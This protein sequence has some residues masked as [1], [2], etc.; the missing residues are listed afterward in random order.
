[1]VGREIHQNQC[2]S[3]NPFCVEKD[4]DASCVRSEETSCDSSFENYCE[5]SLL[6]TCTL[7]HEQATD[8][9]LRGP[10]CVADPDITEIP[11]CMALPVE[12][13]SSDYRVRCNENTLV[14]CRA[15]FVEHHDCA[16]IYEGGICVETTTSTGAASIY[17]QESQ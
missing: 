5:G 4:D 12:P 2:D 3:P 15:G 17:C 9:T 14:T 7:G 8:C 10:D 11:R 1:M 6:I 16:R 13:C